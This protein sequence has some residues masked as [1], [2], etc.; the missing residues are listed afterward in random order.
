M[1]ISDRL[2]HLIQNQDTPCHFDLYERYFTRRTSLQ[3][4]STKIISYYSSVYFQIADLVL[5]W[6]ALIISL[7]LSWRLYKVFVSLPHHSRT[8]LCSRIPGLS[9]AYIQARWSV[10]RHLADVCGMVLLGTLLKPHILT[11][12]S[13]VFSRGFGQHPVVCFHLGQRNGALGRSTSSWCHKGAF[14]SHRRVRWNIH[15][16]DLGR[17]SSDLIAGLSLMFI[18][19]TKLLVPWLIVVGSCLPP[20][21]P[22]ASVLIRTCRAGTPCAE[23]VAS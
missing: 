17:S 22:C 6:D 19:R 1:N 12:L 10:E 23:S 4:W 16:H 5:H 9:Q 15:H 18:Y 11:C 20:A 14:F 2:Q 21:A 8:S 3:V 13:T 7:I